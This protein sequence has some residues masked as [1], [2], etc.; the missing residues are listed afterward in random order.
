MTIC[1]KYALEQEFK[2]LKKKEL[3][4]GKE[5]ITIYGTKDPMPWNEVYTRIRSGNTMEDIVH[6][7]GHARKVTLFAIIDGIDVQKEYVDAV[8]SKIVADRT[9]N[10]IEVVDPV[11]ASTMR[12]M[13]V[14][15]APDL[16]RK[17]IMLVDSAITK[18]QSII[19]GEECTSNDLKNVLAAI[20][21][22]T[23]ITDVTQRHSTVGGNSVTQI[24]I[25]GF[26][27]VEDINPNEVI[28]GEITG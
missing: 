16:Q 8:D 13:V 23:D 17:A 10:A 21:I 26:S 14:E 4:K 3:K 25:D 1:E 12:E 9:M 5:A 2:P 27:I 18:G 28:D 7:Y 24:Q 20:Q 6:I 19:N 22:G 11:A 15:Y